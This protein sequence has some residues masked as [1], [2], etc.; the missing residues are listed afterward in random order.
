MAARGDQVSITWL[1]D[2]LLGDAAD[3]LITE[4]G[5]GWPLAQLP[6]LATD[7]VVVANLEAPITD[8][9]EPAD[10]T[11][12]W[13]YQARPEAAQALRAIGVD[14]LSLA[15]NHSMDRGPVGLANTAEHA[16]DAGLAWF[17]AGADE[18]QA[19][20]PLL[21]EGADQVVAVVGF[22]DTSRDV[23]SAQEPGTRALTT[24]NLT[25][26]LTNARRRG[27]DRVVAFV[28]WGENYQPVDER[29]R[30]WAQALANAGYDLV[31]GTGPHIAQPIEVIDGMPVVYSI[32]NFVFGT[33]GRFD[34]PEDGAGLILTTTF[35]SHDRVTIT[36]AC[37]ATDNQ[38]VEFQPRSC[39]PALA[40][41]VMATVHPALVGH[42]TPATI[43]LPLP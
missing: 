36:V 38:V 16:A 8:Q 34:R 25:T 17:G 13:S 18:T 11:R 40:T 29:Q 6:L 26:D 3:P 19:Q 32:G 7:G 22:V 33:P 35:E 14:A 37:L 2:T 23:A 10:P 21:V 20:L 28:H 27:A 43:E 15:N 41:S 31:V 5:T 12:R 4:H 24:A 9:T 42:G 30:A 1:G 39:P